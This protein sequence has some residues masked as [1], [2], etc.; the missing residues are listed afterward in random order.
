MILRGPLPRQKGEKT[1]KRYPRKRLKGAYTSSIK[2][3]A[4][5]MQFYSIDRKK[6]D[7]FSDKNVKRIF[8]ELVR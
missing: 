1:W 4:L 5:K 3:S 6:I 7:E 2:N 8:S